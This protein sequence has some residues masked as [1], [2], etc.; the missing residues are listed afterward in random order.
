[1]RGKIGSGKSHRA[2]ELCA[3]NGRLLL[4]MDAAMEA[5][6]GKD[7]IGREKHVQAEKGILEYFLSLAVRLHALGVDAVIDHGFWTKA[8]LKIATD[9]L[10]NHGVPYTVEVLEADFATRLSR[11]KNRTDGK[12]FTEDKLLRFDDFYEE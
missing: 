12:T 9:H 7:C 10:E 4:S 2:R 1:M 11:V 5:I 6:H 8:E 3:E